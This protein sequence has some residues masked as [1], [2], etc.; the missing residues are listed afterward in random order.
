MVVVAGEMTLSV[1]SSQSQAQSQEIGGRT[2]ACG[3][4]DILTRRWP[5]QTILRLKQ[6]TS[7]K[8]VVR[9]KVLYQASTGDQDKQRLAGSTT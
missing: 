6:M 7:S 8:Y 9:S 2:A 3:L 5:D 1:R 4:R